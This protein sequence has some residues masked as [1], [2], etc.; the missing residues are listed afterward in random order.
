[1][2]IVQHMFSQSKRWI[3]RAGRRFSLQPK[4]LQILEIILAGVPLLF[5]LVSTFLKLVTPGYDLWQNTI[6]ELVL[7]PHGSI[8]AAVFY[9]LGASIIVV[10]IKLY[11]L[12]RASVQLR[13]GLGLIAL[14]AVGFILLGIF[15]TDPYGTSMT[16]TGEIHVQTTTAIIF[17]FPLAC[18]LL[19]PG[20]K[21]LFKRGWL[22]HVTRGAGVMQ[23]VLVA[24]MAVLV[25]GNLGWVGMVERM[26]MVNSLGWMQIISI[27]ALTG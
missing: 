27:K 1:M 6:S 17:L 7:G 11:I 22:S 5:I 24:A 16:L 26:I 10:I 25:L 8:Q 13:I 3:F 18:F 12:P 9:L 21:R 2:I 19:A 4:P 15:P 20:L 14:C 23:L